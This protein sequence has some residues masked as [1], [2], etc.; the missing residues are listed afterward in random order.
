MFLDA[1][2]SYVQQRTYMEML[3]DQPDGGGST[4]HFFTKKHA[5]GWHVWKKTPRGEFAIIGPH[6]DEATA[7]AQASDFNTMA[8]KLSSK[9]SMTPAAEAM[10]SGMMG[11]YMTGIGPVIQRSRPGLV[12]M[13]NAPL[14]RKRHKK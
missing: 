8:Q 1:L 4:F 2:T 5:N 7:K 10:T 9:Q 14:R 11:A 12:A 6:K 3:L 13:Y